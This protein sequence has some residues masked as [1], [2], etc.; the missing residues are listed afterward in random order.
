MAEVEFGVVVKVKRLCAKLFWFPFC[1]QALSFSLWL[2]FGFVVPKHFHRLFFRLFVRSSFLFLGLFFGT[3]WHFGLVCHLI[4]LRIIACFT[5]VSTI[6][7]LF[8]GAFFRAFG[9]ALGGR[10]FCL[11]GCWQVGFRFVGLV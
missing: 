10:T 5:F 2:V 1:I 4:A 9:G 8:C 7:L 11:F 3:A 6:R